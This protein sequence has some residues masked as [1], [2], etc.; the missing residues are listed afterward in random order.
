MELE[1]VVGGVQEEESASFLANF[2][3]FVEVGIA[4]EVEI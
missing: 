1:G 4:F 2:P 3:N